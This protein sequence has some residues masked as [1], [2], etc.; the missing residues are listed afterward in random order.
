[1][2][3]FDTV[4]IDLNHDALRRLRC[5]ARLDIVPR[6]GHLFEESGAL[7]KVA[8]LAQQWFNEYLVGTHAGVPHYSVAS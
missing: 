4:V 3:G 1:M 8:D 6:A 2:G 7:E 5:I